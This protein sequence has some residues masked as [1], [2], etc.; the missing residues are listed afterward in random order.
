MMFEKEGKGFSGMLDRVGLMDLAQVASFGY[1]SADLEI[2]S[3]M[4]NGM[5]NIRSGQI[6]HCE[7]GPIS[8]EEALCRIFSWPGGSFEF[9]P[10]QK[11]IRQSIEKT[12]EQ[13]LVESVLYRLEAN[14]ESTAAETCFSGEIAGMDLLDIVQLAWLSKVDRLLTVTAEERKGIILFNER[15]AFHAAYGTDRGESAFREMALAKRG[16]F[17]SC[18]PEE[19]EPVTIK[20]SLEDLLVEANLHRDEK[21]AGAHGGGIQNLLQRIQRMKVTEKIRLALMG[22]KE[23]RMALARDSNRMVQL[24]VLGNPKLSGFEVTLIA[25][26]RSTDDEVFRRIAA[27][28]EWMRHHQVKAALVNNPKCPIPIASKVIET[29]G[30]QEWKRIAANR[31]VPSVICAIAKRLISKKT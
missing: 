9:K 11:E 6:Y 10:E 29:L 2:H 13:L 8:G 14:M 7:T 16:T 27:S 22:N 3:A 31:S 4:G 1:M 20:R 25:T 21:R 15:G 26:S 12:W 19:D 28:R 30:R 17:E 24:A 23:T 5:I 18:R